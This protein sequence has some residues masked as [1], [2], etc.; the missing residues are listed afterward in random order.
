MKIGIIGLGCVGKPM[1]ESFINKIIELKKEDD[2]EIIGYD[3]YKNGGIGSFDLILMCDILFTVLPTPYN[4][5]LKSYDN[6]ATTETLKLLSEYNYCGVIVIKSTVEP[7]FCEKMIGMF[8]NLSIVHNPEF[9]T[10][11][12]AYDDFHHQKHIV[13]GKTESCKTHLYDSV[14]KLYKCLYPDAEISECSST[15]SECMKIFCNSFYAVKIQFFN[16]L[17]L[18]TDKIGTDYDNIKNLMIK[19]GWIN[20]MHT[21][22]PGTDGKLSYGGMCFPKDTNAL[23]SFMKQCN[24][25]MKVLESCI[26]ERNE[27]RYNE[28][29]RDN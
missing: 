24:V 1:M 13:L 10:A 29:N 22:V 23:Y 9:L 2:Y 5:E 20:K 15:E 28:L 26:N 14:V 12:T 6:S 25:P 11:K 4:D 18:L 21:N 3:K 19:N 17:Y 8:S 7:L 16:E 27:M